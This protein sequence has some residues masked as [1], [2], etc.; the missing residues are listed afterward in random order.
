MKQK[1]RI[2]IWSVFGVVCFVFGAFIIIFPI[3]GPDSYKFKPSKGY[4]G[5]VEPNLFVQ[6]GFELSH[7]PG[8]YSKEF[9]LSATIPS[10]PTAIVRW[11]IDG[12]EPRN[13][14]QSGNIDIVDRSANWRN[15]QLTRHSGDWRVNNNVKPNFNAHVLRGT[16]LKMRGFV[17]GEPIT[18]TINATYIIAPDV[19]TRFAQT[20]IISITA[21]YSDFMFLY[22]NADPFDPPTSPDDSNAHRRIFNFEYFEFGDNGYEP[23]F[24]MPGWTWLGGAASRPNAQR[25]FNV[26]V[27]RG[28]LSGEIMHPIFEDVDSFTRFRLWNGGNSFRTDHLRDPFAQRA[29]RDMEV[30]YSESK[31]MM[32]FINGEFWGFTTM[33]EHTSNV[34]YLGPKTG[35]ADNNIALLDGSWTNGEPSGFE[36]EEGGWRA[37]E[38]FDELVAFLTT[39][40][41]KTDEGRAR[42]F[43]EFFCEDNFIDNLIVRSFWDDW[44]FGVNNTRIYRAMN[45]PWRNVDPNPS[46]KYTDG[47]W[48]FILHDMDHSVRVLGVPPYSQPRDSRLFPRLYPDVAHGGS[49]V[50][51]NVWRVLNNTAFAEKLRERAVEVMENHY[52]TEKLVALHQE[53]VDARRPL[54]NEMYNRFPTHGNIFRSRANFNR[55]VRGVNNFLHTRHEHYLSILDYIVERTINPDATWDYRPR[56]AFV[57]GI[58][59]SC[60]IGLPIIIGTS[61]G[62]SVYRKRKKRTTAPYK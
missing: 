40:D 14:S 19:A 60:S 45:R 21:E 38:A 53:F 49:Q 42:L 44:D 22:S 20:P 8:V 54:L 16:T 17:N 4:Q 26:N 18:D 5:S 48:R 15:T 24:N 46:N 43:D 13:T 3:V 34:A 33:R 37:R 28:A 25:T 10:H 52:T 6:G 47:K 30:L 32:K 55:H 9:V 39:A 27:A 56:S 11:T 7:A 58:I 23:V 31:L 12:S 41:L 36:V 35:I 62:V 59:I 51:R 61:V 57:T 2:W 1:K 50:F 29:S